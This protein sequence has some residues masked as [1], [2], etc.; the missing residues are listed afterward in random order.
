VG[1][2][3]AQHVGLNG[4]GLAMEAGQRGRLGNSSMEV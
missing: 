1:A 4:T 3:V 2:V